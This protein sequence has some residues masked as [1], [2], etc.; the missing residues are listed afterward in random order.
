VFLDREFAIRGHWT[1]DHTLGQL[2]V[3]GSKLL[4][5]EKDLLDFA[6]PPVSG[7]VEVDGSIQPTPQWR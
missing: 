6:H 7:H 2:S 1:V 4:L 5:D 3:S